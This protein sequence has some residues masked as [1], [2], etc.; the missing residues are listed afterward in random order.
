MEVFGV[1]EDA[2]NADFVFGRVKKWDSMAH[3]ALIEALENAFGVMFE[4][5]DILHY[6]SYLHGIEIL[7]KYGVVF[8]AVEAVP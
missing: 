3:M 8:D 4:T 2:L 7:T 6:G 5:E 1:S